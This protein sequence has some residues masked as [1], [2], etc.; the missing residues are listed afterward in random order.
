MVLARQPLSTAVMLQVALLVILAQIGCYVPATF[1][2]ISPYDSLYTRVGT[3]D[4]IENNASSFM[5][6]MSDMAHFMDR[7]ATPWCVCSSA[8]AQGAV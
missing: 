5:V 4:S 7:W 1:M 6:E 8:V 2:A 3:A